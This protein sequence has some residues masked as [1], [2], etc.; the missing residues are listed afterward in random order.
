MSDYYAAEKETVF[1]VVKSIISTHTNIKEN[2][3]YSRDTQ[4]YLTIIVY[5]NNRNLICRFYLNS[6]INKQ[7]AFVDDNKNEEKYKINS[8]DDIYSFADR[9]TNI[10]K[11]YETF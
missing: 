1:N 11:R 2:D 8:I 9:I 4:S 10:A 6:I 5:N 7:I 3:V